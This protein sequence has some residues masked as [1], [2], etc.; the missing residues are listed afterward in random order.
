MKKPSGE[1]TSYLI[2]ANIAFMFKKVNIL[3]FSYIITISFL[4]QG[5]NNKDEKNENNNEEWTPL[6]NGK[7]LTGWDIKIKDHPLNENYKNTFR[8]EDSMLRVSYSDYG[9]FDNQFGHLYTQAPYSYYKLKLQYRFVGDHLADGRY[10][11]TEIAASCSILNRQ[12]VWNCTRISRCRWSFNFSVAMERILIKPGMFVRR[13]HLSHMTG[14][15]L[16][17]T[18]FRQTVKPI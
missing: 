12:R 7:D 10:G 6:F 16:Q 11:Q 14:K 3:L 1:S 13:V 15:F 17:A 4:L 18:F 2:T 9:K 8:V 5:C